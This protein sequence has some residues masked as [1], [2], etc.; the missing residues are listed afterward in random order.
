MEVTI[1][2]LFL[3]L[4]V[5][6]ALIRTREKRICRDSHFM[7]S[8]FEL[9]ELPIEQRIISLKQWEKKAY[10]QAYPDLYKSNTDALQSEKVVPIHKA[11]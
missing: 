6:V 11:I 8:Y 9:L 3:M 1:Y 7:R 2:A 4:I 5:V 10:K